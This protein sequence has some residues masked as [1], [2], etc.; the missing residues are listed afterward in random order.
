MTR[1][2]VKD[3]LSL[4][5]VV[6]LVVCVG[7]EG[8]LRNVE[9]TATSSALIVTC[10]GLLG[11]SA[12]AVCGR[13]AICTERITH[14]A[15]LW[16]EW[17]LRNPGLQRRHRGGEVGHQK[18]TGED[19]VGSYGGRTVPDNQLKY[20]TLATGSSTP[21]TESDTTAGRQSNVRSP[22]FVIRVTSTASAAR[23]RVTR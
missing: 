13:V 1:G 7:P 16:I 6:T 20:R 21:S 10:G 23:N 14:V 4:K 22:P 19:V 18:E 5:F 9:A 15:C 11:R 12:V 17:T 2:P 8:R 3:P